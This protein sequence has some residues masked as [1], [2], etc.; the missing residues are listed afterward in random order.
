MKKLKVICF[1]LALVLFF[2]I[3]GNLRINSVADSLVYGDCNGDSKVNAKDVLTLR[4]QIVD[5]SFEIAFD[6]ADVFND[7]VLNAKDVL[8]IR[9]YLAGI[10]VELGTV[11]ESIYQTATTKYFTSILS[12]IN[13]L[14]RSTVVG[15]KIAGDFSGSG[16]EFEL[17]CK[18][19]VIVNLKFET[20]DGNL[21]VVI[22]DDYEN[23]QVVAVEAYLSKITIA[24]DLQPGVYKFRVAK[25]NE[26]NKYDSGT[27][28]IFNS[29]TY[30]GLLLKKP[31]QKELKIEWYG[32]SLTCG[33]GNLWD[34]SMSQSPKQ[35][36]QN[37]Y[38]TFPVFASRALNAEYSFCSSSGYGLVYSNQGN[39]AN[40][41][42]GIW[43][44]ALPMKDPAL[45]YDFGFDPDIIVIT[46]GANDLTYTNNSKVSVSKE[47]VQNAAR[48]LLSNIRS[49]YPN[50]HI[51]WLGGFNSWNATK[52]Y[53]NDYIDIDSAIKEIDEQDDM[54]WYKG[55]FTN[56]SSGLHTHPNVDEHK[57]MAELV[58]EFIKSSLGDKIKFD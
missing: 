14:G 19:D 26:F 18:G 22:N 50:V 28:V 34:S 37:G 20:T 45:E 42:N 4:K 32:D 55:N 1:A 5:N 49:K 44:K 24:R 31:A 39:E 15:S 13:L 12:N 30:N 51:V 56:T 41:L 3:S 54:L 38:F 9:K 29:V 27:T 46:I 23:M 16:I 25:L 40:T 57:K 36:Y 33:Y 52:T 7:F 48:K 6:N 8:L 11:D 47:T 43:N 21:G 17:N 35:K 10:D 58:S 2:S 53:K